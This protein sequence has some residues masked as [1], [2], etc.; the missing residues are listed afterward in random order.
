MITD[1]INVIGGDIVERGLHILEQTDEVLR[2]TRIS[3]QNAVNI[4]P[5]PF[6]HNP[7]AH[8]IY[9]LFTKAILVPT[10]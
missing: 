2:V 5:G 9:S 10:R 1:E 7:P 4:R 8:P 3:L 6:H